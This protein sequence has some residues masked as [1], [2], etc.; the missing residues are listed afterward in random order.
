MLIRVPDKWLYKMDLNNT[1]AASA[2]DCSGATGQACP[3]PE[4]ADCNQYKPMECKLLRRSYSST[5]DDRLLRP[6]N[7]FTHQ[8]GFPLCKCQ[9][10]EQHTIDLVECLPNYGGLQASSSTGEGQ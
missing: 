2:I 4:G 9:I 1:G 3:I 5:D 7:C 6:N 10:T 8:R